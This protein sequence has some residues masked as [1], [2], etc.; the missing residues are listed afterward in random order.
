MRKSFGRFPDG[1][2][3]VG[4]QDHL[5]LVLIREARHSPSQ[6]A[7]SSPKK[8]ENLHAECHSLSGSFH[9]VEISLLALS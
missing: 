7:V 6:S 2:R 8:A 1:S 4:A 3:L 5:L 9:L